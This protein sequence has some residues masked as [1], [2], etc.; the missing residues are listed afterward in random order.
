MGVLIDSS[1]LIHFERSDADLSAYIQGREEE[2][3]FLSVISASELLHGVH[4]A[5][6]KRIKAKRLAFV[7]GVLDSLP[8]LVI[9][10]ATAR[11]HSQL[12]ADLA[13]QGKMIGVHDSWL[14][15]TCLA[16]GLRLATSNLREFDRVPG[17]DVEKWE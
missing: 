10:L 16:H 3:A 12:W 7:E 17:L 1:V 9:N 11:S 2:E 5:K 6:D 14:A 13:R 8:I 15:A 4:R